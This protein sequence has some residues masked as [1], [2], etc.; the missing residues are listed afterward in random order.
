MG[1]RH[2]ASWSHIGAAEAEEQHGSTTST[3]HLR[4]MLSVLAHGLALKAIEHQKPH[5]RHVFDGVANAFPA[6]A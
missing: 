6:Q 2:L 3:R 5:F 4:A 1:W